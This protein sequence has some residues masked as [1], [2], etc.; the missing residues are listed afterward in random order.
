MS[1]HQLET[2]FILDT[3]TGLKAT[4]NDNTSDENICWVL[5]NQLLE[6]KPERFNNIGNTIDASGV[7]PLPILEGDTI[8]FTF[9]I[10]PASNQH[11]LTGVSEIN[12]REYQ[13]K[14]VV[15]DGSGINTL[16]IDVGGSLLS[17]SGNIQPVLR[18]INI[19][20]ST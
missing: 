4:T 3:V 9:S 19:R 20:I 15:D 17:Y 12:P 16:P 11:Q 6:S 13:I 5:L 18:M 2:G 10:S 1:T 8:S 7:F 14:I